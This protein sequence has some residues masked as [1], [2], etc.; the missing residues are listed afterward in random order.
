MSRGVKK[1][2][3][4]EAAASSALIEEGSRVAEV[5][6]WSFPAEA[7]A[8]ATVQRPKNRHRFRALR[9]SLGCLGPGACDALLAGEAGHEVDVSAG[10]SVPLLPQFLSALTALAALTS[11]CAV[12]LA[13]FPCGP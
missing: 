2:F 12:S 1:G 7:V 5:T 11:F 13:P 9:R 4:E 10:L 6:C 3:L 8:A